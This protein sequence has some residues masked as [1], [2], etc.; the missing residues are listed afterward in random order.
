MAKKNKGLR[1]FIISSL[2][3]I[4][5]GVGVLIGSGS[6]TPSVK[7]VQNE[8]LRAFEQIDSN[9]A[10][11]EAVESDKAILYVSQKSCPYCAV[12]GPKLESAAESITDTALYEY[13]VEE[14]A[15][16]NLTNVVEHRAYL[17][18]ETTPSVYIIEDGNVTLTDL[19]SESSVEEILAELN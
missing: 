4:G 3:L 1:I 8:P 5:L 9:V 7:S 14:A 19:D 2:L 16:K 10:F 18:L 17:E 6:T 12:F 13:D 15:E 11:R